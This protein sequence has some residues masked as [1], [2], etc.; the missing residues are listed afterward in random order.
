M[1][2]SPVRDRF[3]F[4]KES[5]TLYDIGVS[6]FVA[7]KSRTFRK[8]DG[9]EK[10]FTCKRFEHPHLWSRSSM[11]DVHVDMDPLQSTV[12][13]GSANGVV[14]ADK[15]QLGGFVKIAQPFGLIEPTYVPFGI[16][17]LSF[18]SIA[19]VSVSDMIQ[20]PISRPQT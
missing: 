19:K 7:S 4:A 2:S 8:G 3:C 15:V 20:P 18:S 14:V 1:N 9:V 17:G 6:G 11:A 16:L 5:L 12:G 13:G 10:T